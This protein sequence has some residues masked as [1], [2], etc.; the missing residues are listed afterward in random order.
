MKF[1]RAVEG[2]YFTLTVD[3]VKADGNLTG[4]WHG[5]HLLNKHMF[6]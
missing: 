5:G 4:K 6:V 3:D 2:N 1:L